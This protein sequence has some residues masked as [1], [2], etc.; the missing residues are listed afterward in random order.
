MQKS[1]HKTNLQTTMAFRKDIIKQIFSLLI[2]L[3]AFTPSAFAQ[4]T[5]DT[6][7]DTVRTVDIYKEFSETSF[8][9]A[10]I[11]IKDS[12][13]LTQHL[14]GVKGGYSIAKVGFSQA[15]NH[16]GIKTPI[17]FGIYYTYYHSLWNSMPYFGFQTGLEY[18]E[19]GYNHITTDQDD[20]IVSEESQIYQTIQLPLTSQ[21]R[22]DFWKM[23]LLVN[24]GPYGYYITSTNLKDGIPATTN[25]VGVGIMG[26]G[27][28]AFVFKPVEFHLECNYKY[29]MSH[30]CNPKIYSEEHWVYTHANQLIFSLGVF[31]RLGDGK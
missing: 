2:L 17:N 6:Q 3:S 23:R 28:L 18:A 1:K 14:I 26:G 10:T 22:I 24:L 13:I 8:E 25:K 27:G 21:F 30:F 4:N 31:F 19:I 16:T 5:N 9:N 29:A 15:F 7:R 12:T 11:K 20:N